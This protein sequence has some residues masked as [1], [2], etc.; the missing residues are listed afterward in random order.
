MEACPI[1]VQIKIGS[2]PGEQLGEVCG[3]VCVVRCVVG[4]VWREGRKLATLPFGR[5]SG[6][7]IPSPWQLITGGSL[8]TP[9]S[10]TTFEKSEHTHTTLMSVHAGETRQW[11]VRAGKTR[12]WSVRAGETR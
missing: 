6:H 8:C 3:G 10:M 11:S 12:Q 4:C 5:V 7:A 1:H 2:F 9:V